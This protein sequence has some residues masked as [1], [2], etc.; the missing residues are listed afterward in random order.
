MRAPAVKTDIA[1]K[2][3]SEKVASHSTT[4]SATML[5]QHC[6]S[7]RKPGGRVRSNNDC[8][9]IARFRIRGLVRDRASSPVIETAAPQSVCECDRNAEDRRKEGDARGENYPVLAA[10]A[11]VANC[12]F[13]CA[14]VTA[15]DG[16]HPGQKNS[17][18]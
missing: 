11:R 2:T 16:C 10:Q 18:R 7:T 14:G 4:V 1:V 8:S 6:Y 17:P 12:A 9:C 13:P 5:L 3:E 15:I